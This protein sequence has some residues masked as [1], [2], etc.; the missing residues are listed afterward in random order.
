MLLRMTWAFSIPFA[1]IFFKICAHIRGMNEWMNGTLLPH[2]PFSF[3]RFSHKNEKRMNNEK[4][5]ISHSCCV[6]LLCLV[7]LLSLFLPIY[8]TKDL[9]WKLFSMN[10]VMCF[11]M[12]TKPFTVGC[13]FNLNIKIHYN[14]FLLIK[15]LNIIAKKSTLFLRIIICMHFSFSINL[16]WA[17]DSIHF[18]INAHSRQIATVF[19]WKF[20]WPGI[21]NKEFIFCIENI[22]A[23]KTM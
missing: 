12:D 11:S 13:T 20:S 3:I 14:F 17:Y 8:R 7:P 18:R 15:W 16:Q 1:Y 9:L 2:F 10:Y 4:R 23:N 19:L 21:F 6:F 5:L 22:S